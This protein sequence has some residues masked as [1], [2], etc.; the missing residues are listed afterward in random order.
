MSTGVEDGLTA[1]S[2]SLS[3]DSEPGGV[4]GSSSWPSYVDE[5]VE[6]NDG[7]RGGAERRGDEGPS[8][9]SRRDAGCS[10]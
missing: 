6:A 2:D 1:D 4:D 9:G 8:R 7:V 5:R 3:S 10:V